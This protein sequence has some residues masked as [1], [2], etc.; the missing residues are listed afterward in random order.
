MCQSDA[1]HGPGNGIYPLKQ[2]MLS[3]VD[4]YCNFL[5]L[6][7][8][9]LGFAWPVEGIGKERTD[10]KEENKELFVFYLGKALKLTRQCEDLEDFVY[11]PDSE[12]IVAKFRNGTKKMINVECDSCWAMIKD[13]LRALG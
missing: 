6:S 11:Y 12:E 4:F 7:N 3:I 13:A 2:T 1:L 10:M 9:Y 5:R 8:K